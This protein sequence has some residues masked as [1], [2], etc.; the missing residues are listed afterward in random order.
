MFQKK[1]LPWDAGGKADTLVMRFGNGRTLEFDIKKVP[2]EIKHQ[3]ALMGLGNTCGDPAAGFS[4]TNDYAGAIAACENRWQG[5]LDGVWSRKGGRSGS[6]D[7]AAALARVGK[8]DLSQAE[9]LLAVADEEVVKAL[10]GDPKVKSAIKD[11]QAERAAQVAAAA[12]P[13]EKDV[14]SILADL[15]KRLPASPAK[16]KSADKPAK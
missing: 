12:P 1:I 5:F 7:L 14:G 15:A 16:P 8:I 9:A 6:T 3:L 10:L 4:K 2:D 11:I 13:A